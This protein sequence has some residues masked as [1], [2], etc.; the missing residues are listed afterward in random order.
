[1]PIP[2]VA[3]TYSWERAA[4]LDD[5][6]G[7]ASAAARRALQ[8]PDFLFFGRLN[9]DPVIQ[10]ADAK[11]SVET[12][13]AKQVS[14]EVV[15]GILELGPVLS[16]LTGM[17][18]AKTTAVN[19]VFLCPDFALTQIM[20]LRRK[21]IVRATVNSGQVVL[22]PVS[23]SQFFQDIEGASLISPL[24]EVDALL[25]VSADDL[26][27][28]LYY[29]RLG[30]AAIG[31]WLDAN[32]PLLS[33]G[34]RIQV[35]ESKVHAEMERRIQRAPSAYA[36]ILDWQLE[37]QPVR[38]QRASIAQATAAPIV[39]QHLRDMVG[40]AATKAGRNPPPIN[41]IRRQLSSWYHT[42][43][44]ERVGAIGPPVRDMGWLL[45]RIT[46]AR[47]DLLPELQR[48]TIRAVGEAMRRQIPSA[49][50][51]GDETPQIVRDRCGLIPK[52]LTSPDDHLMLKARAMSVSNTSS[53]GSLD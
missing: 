33:D 25:G 35:D 46:R 31:A 23:A 32:N 38:D 24:R 7:V 51:D 40:A 19:G 37:V 6:P 13:R 30:R 20:L 34:P 29:F 48:E 21:G 22:V 42:K 9:G 45:R 1:M 36:L 12:A 43:M 27:V 10:A 53:K 50:G 39:S 18:D 47:A 49:Q 44:L 16:E 28:A 14:P 52:E 3:K 11:F 2:Q 4:R 8:N 26:M 5:M 15:S 41:T 17:I